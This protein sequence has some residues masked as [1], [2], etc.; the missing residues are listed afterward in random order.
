MDIVQARIQQVNGL[1]SNWL[2]LKKYFGLFLVWYNWRKGQS[3][4]C[5]ERSIW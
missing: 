1:S 4:K 5:R 3:T 2:K